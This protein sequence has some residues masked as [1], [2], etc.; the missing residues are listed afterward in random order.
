MRLTIL[1]DTPYWIGLLEVERN[2]YLYAAQHIFGTE[3][4]DAEVNELVQRH[5]LSL[6]AQMTVGIPV[7]QRNEPSR[8]NP[9]RVQREI[10]HQI[11]EPGMSSK[12]HEA[13]R[14]QIEQNKRESAQ[15]L[16]Q[17]RETLRDYKRELG[18]QK[19]KA[20]HIGR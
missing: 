5:L 14:L 16:R 15:Q 20:R 13:I 6:Q 12:A 11:A 1:F 2:G 3:P 8:P 18:R 17:T 19:A 7:E 10:C 9:K 4:S